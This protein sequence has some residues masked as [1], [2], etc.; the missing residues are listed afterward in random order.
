MR[1]IEG[2]RAGARD[3]IA[4]CQMAVKD[5][6]VPQRHLLIQRAKAAANERSGASDKSI[7]FVF[8][9]FVA[10]LNTRN[11]APMQWYFCLGSV[12][13]SVILTS[14]RVVNLIFLAF[15]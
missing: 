1:I 7:R 15:I 13:N 4:L 14:I 5:L 8:K 10:P 11:A 6:V 3:P 12:P 2:A 9:N